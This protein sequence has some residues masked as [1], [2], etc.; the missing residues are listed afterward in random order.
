M[1]D[2]LSACV[3]GPS[4]YLPFPLGSLL[5]ALV[6]AQRAETTVGLVPCP[7]PL[8]HAVVAIRNARRPP[9]R[10]HGPQGNPLFRSCVA[11]SRLTPSHAR[12]SFCSGPSFFGRSREHGGDHGRG[13]NAPPTGHSPI[14]SSAMKQDK[15]GRGNTCQFPRITVAQPPG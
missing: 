7:C 6:A 11:P 2:S 13:A 12:A 15:A 4:P 9:S 5:H 3:T 14:I 8:L 1:C 10:G